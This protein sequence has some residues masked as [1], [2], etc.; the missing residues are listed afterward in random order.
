M[1]CWRHKTPIIYRA[2]TQWFA[3][4][5]EPPGYKGVKPAESLA[6]DR[7]ARHRQHALLSGLGPG[8]PARH[9]RQSSRLDF[10]A[11]AP[12][13]RAHA[14][15]HPQGNGRAA[16]AHTGS[17][18]TG[19]QARGA[20]RHR[21]LADAGSEGTAGRGSGAIRQDQGHARRLVRFRLHASDRDGRAGGQARPAPVRTGPICNS[22]PTCTSKVPTSIAAGSIRR[23]WCRAC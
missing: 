22:R 3:A 11:P 17:A 21:G 8:A 19:G 10:V 23:C 14:L 20:G 13:G 16:S 6:H 15:L 9:D 2:S 4:M 1:H 18:G 5:D 7:P 12:M